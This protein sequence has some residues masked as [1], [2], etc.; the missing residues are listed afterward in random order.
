MSIVCG[1]PSE[2][3]EVLAL[4]ECSVGQFAVRITKDLTPAQDAI[5]DESQLV[6]MRDLTDAG[7]SDR[8]ALRGSAQEVLS[9][10]GRCDGVN[11]DARNPAT[12]G[13]E[14]VSGELPLALSRHR[15]VLIAK[16]DLTQKWP[17]DER[18]LSVRIVRSLKI[19]S[20]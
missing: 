12:M 7:P 17:L 1:Q 5:R 19:R 13:V 2:A 11:R 15:Q 6:T 16:L 4:L 8:P 9:G 18:P 20:S 14:A 10:R 3:L